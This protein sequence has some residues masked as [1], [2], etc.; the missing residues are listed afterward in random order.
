M[1]VN[2][3]DHIEMGLML[4]LNHTVPLS[5]EEIIDGFKCELKELGYSWMMLV[6]RSRKREI[7]EIRQIVQFLLR[8]ATEMTYKE[9]GMMFDRDHATVLYSC[10]QV[11]DLV[12]LDSA[13]CRKFKRILSAVKYYIRDRRFPFGI[14]RYVMDDS[15]TNQ[16][17]SNTI[18]N[19]LQR[20]TV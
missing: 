15:N 6:G 18:K 2:S 1:K 11:Q 13:Y 4:R 5:D 16:N 14:M 19:V 12:A 8:C 17:D 9:I 10:N 20:N 7:V 3:F